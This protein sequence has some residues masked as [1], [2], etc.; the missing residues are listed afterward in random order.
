MYGEVPPDAVTVADPSQA[1]LQDTL[2]LDVIVAV[3]NGGSVIVTV[4]VVSQPL[5]SVT[6]TV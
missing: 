5:P 1:P 4:A 6:V 3:N 2:V